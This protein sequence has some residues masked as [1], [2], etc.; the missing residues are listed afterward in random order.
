MNNLNRFKKTIVI[1]TLLLLALSAT[2][3]LSQ[4][5]PVLWEV[6]FSPGGG[7]A[8]AIVKELNNAKVSV[9]IQ[10]Y[11]LT[12]TTIAKALLETHKRGVRVDVILD[13]SQRTEK[14][15]SPT[16][17]F[18]AGIRV[19]IDSKHGK[20]HDKIIIIDEETVITGS[21]NFTNAAEKDN[22]ENLLVVRDK[23]LAKRYIKNWNF[24]AQHSETY[25]G[26]IK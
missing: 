7:A 16:F 3:T 21:Y 24:H 13:K 22:A 8:D 23:N 26:P 6:Y 20:A 15:S 4:E 1:T 19:L 18:N 11:S 2:D 5:G 9:L 25:E 10:A 14:Y 12:S 17:L